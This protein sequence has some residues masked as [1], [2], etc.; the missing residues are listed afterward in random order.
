M[1]IEFSTIEKKRAREFL[2]HDDY[3]FLNDEAREYIIN[4]LGGVRGQDP[5]M[6]SPA[7]LSMESKEHYDAIMGIQQGKN[8]Q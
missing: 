2:K 6:Y 1:N 7:R 8:V 4:N 3:S 5:A